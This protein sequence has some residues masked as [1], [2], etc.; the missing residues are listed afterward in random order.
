M[1]LRADSDR[2]LHAADDKAGWGLSLLLGLTHVSLIFDGIIF[3]PIMIGKATLTPPEQVAFVTFAT[4]IVAALGT[5]I[6]TLRVGRIGCGFVLFMGSYSAFLACTLGAVRMGGLELMATMTLLSAPVVFFYSYFLRF[7][8][9]I[10]TPQIGGIMIILVAL[11]LMPIAIELWQGGL[12]DRPGFG[13]ASNYIVGVITMS[14]LVLLMLFGNTT[15]RLWTPLLGLGAGCAAAW[16]FGILELEQAV[17]A[18]WIGLPQWAWPGLELDLGLSHV[19][20]L[21]AF[22]MAAVVSS[23]EGTG[24]IMLVQQFS[25]RRFRKVDYQRVQTGLYGDAVAKGLAG[26]SG[27]APVA[28]FCDN[29]PL[30]KMTR[31]ASRRVGLMGAAILFALAFMPK[32]S[33]FLLD[34]P[35]PVIG[36]MLVV[37]CGMLFA[38]G[39]SLI[40]SSGLSFQIGLILGLSLCAGLVAETR[41]FFPDVMPVALSPVL[42]SGVAM[43]GFVAMAMSLLLVLFPKP[44]MTFR[45]LPRTEEMPKLLATLEDVRHKFKISDTAFHR[46]RLS[47]EET[48]SHLCEHVADEGK[49]CL[50]DIQRKEEGMFVE[51]I[52]GS[53]VEDVDRCPP[54]IHPSCA[55]DQDLSRLGLFL[56]AKMAR[57]VLHF[58]LSGNT[59]ITFYIDD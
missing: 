14:A 13:S 29:L 17:S 4:I 5:L 7:L 25:L 12:P 32:I 2:I 48:F 20:L 28:T 31:V 43:G 52:C 11:S 23:M 33:G 37:I 35:A 49:T 6:Q 45:L 8:R 54:P 44:Q 18:P 47:C 26:L 42:Q 50:F 46:L 56:L 51:I 19:P 16:F 55:N 30:L 24:N 15:L 39:I 38:A 3:L 21:A 34:L 40:I 36:G 59:Y 58:H 1:T 9:H 22:V 27:A 41:N 57:D 53:Q 10:V